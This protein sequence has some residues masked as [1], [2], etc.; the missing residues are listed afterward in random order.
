[1]FHD[2]VGVQVMEASADER[3]KYSPGLRMLFQTYTCFQDETCKMQMK[4]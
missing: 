3:R 1:M 2:F 4:R